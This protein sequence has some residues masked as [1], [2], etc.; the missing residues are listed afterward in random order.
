[1]GNIGGCCDRPD[2]KDIEVHEQPTK[3]IQ[4]TSAHMATPSAVAAVEEK[5]MEAKTEY[6]I[7]LDRSH[8]ERLGIDVD[9]EGNG[10]II[11]NIDKTEGLVLQWNRVNYNKVREG[12]LIVEVN[13]VRDDV[14]KMVAECKKETVL[15][16]VLTRGV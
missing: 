5:K 14:T 16:M 2:D 8:G 10:L 6:K 11:E 7:R 4:T 13:K 12:D 1:M 3:Q 15:E 9:Q